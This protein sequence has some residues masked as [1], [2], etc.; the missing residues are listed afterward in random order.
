MENRKLKI[1]GSKI[2]KKFVISNKNVKIICN[3]I[4]RE[5]IQNFKLVAIISY[6]RTILELGF[7]A[8]WLT[9]WSPLPQFFGPFFIRKYF[10]YG[11][12]GR[13][14]GNILREVATVMRYISTNAS[15]ILYCKGHPP[16]SCRDQR[17]PFRIHW[18]TKVASFAIKYYLNTSFKSWSSIIILNAKNHQP[19][20]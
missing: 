10:N 2:I 4:L 3:L 18:K 20:A 6:S 11:F 17:I 12:W 5:Y 13:I 14:S 19:R 16:I 15:H 1:K 9:F 7:N 8:L